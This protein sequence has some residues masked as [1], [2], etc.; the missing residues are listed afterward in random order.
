MTRL[1]KLWET[2]F[3]EALRKV[4]AQSLQ[5]RQSEAGQRVDWKTITVLLTAALCLT[6]QNYANP[7]WVRPAVG[8]LAGLVGGPDGERAAVDWLDAWTA[9]RLGH[10]T[11]WASVAV[12]TYAVIPALVIRLGFRER[13]SDYG[14]KLRGALTGWPVYLVFV[15]VMVPLVHLFSAEDRFQATYPF[16]RVTSPDEV[17]ERLLWWELLYALQFVALEFFF[18]GFLVHGTKHRFGVYAVLVMTVPYCMIHYGKPL[19]EA[20]AS[21]IA[22]VALGLIS[23]ATRSVWLG[24]ALHISVAWGMDLACLARRGLLFP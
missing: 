13:L 17:D 1:R 20:L 19:P 15:A 5:Y 21:I 22:G 4:E 3:G 14:V 2:W 8:F 16:Y 9:D 24:A 23:L 10:L 12:L 6:V 11:W 7:S 18:R